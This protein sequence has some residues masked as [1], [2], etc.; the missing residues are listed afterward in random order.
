LKPSSWYVSKFSQNK[1][2]EKE[3][4]REEKARKEKNSKG[5]VISSI[6]DLQIINIF[7]KGERRK[8]TTIKM[9]S[10]KT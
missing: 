3:K 2:K 5:R 8:M 9:I 7:N 6:D 10:A 4:K 1:R